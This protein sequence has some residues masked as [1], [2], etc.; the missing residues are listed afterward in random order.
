MP[1]HKILS[2]VVI[3][4]KYARYLP[5]K[6]RRETWEEIVDRMLLMHAK[7]LDLPLTITRSL[8][9]TLI[10]K[11]V[12]PSM[13]MLQFGGA[14]VEL[15]QS[16]GYNCASV[17]ADNPAIGWETMFLLLGGTGVGYSVQ[18]HHVAHLPVVQGPIARNRRHVIGDSIEGWAD[19]IK[20]LLRAYFEGRSSPVFEYNDIR[21]KGTLL[22]TSGGK[23]PGPA[24]LKRCIQAVR[25][26][27]DNAVGRQLKPIE[28]HSMLCHIADAVLAGGIRRAAMIALFSLNDLEMLYSKHGA[29]YEK[30]PH[31]GRANNSVMLDRNRITE[32][33][34]RRL[35]EII[36]QG[37]TGEPGIY[38]TNDIEQGTNPCVEIALR[39][40]Q[41]CNL[42][43]VNVSDVTTQEEL[44][45]RVR[46]ASILG[47]VQAS[48]TDFHYIREDWKQN[49]DEE[50]L[51]G[52]S[53]TG[54]ASGGVLH[55]D[56]E[57][58]AAV[59]V[60]VN[61]LW[62]DIL[63]INPAARVTCVKP[64]GTTSLVCGTSNG[65]HAWH[66]AYYLRRMRVGKEES[67]YKYLKD[68]LPQYVEDDVTDP[69]QAILTIPVKAPEG[70]TLRSESPLELLARVKKFSNEWI[71]P[72]HISGPNT[73][74][75]SATIP[76]KPE[77]WPEITDWMWENR[78]VY[79]GLSL[80]PFA[81]TAYKQT[82]F[83]EITRERYEELAKGLSSI[84]LTQ[85]IE[86]QDNTTLVG[87]AA[88]AGGACE[89]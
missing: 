13:R 1:A 82:P 17:A 75:V 50:S 43:E 64:A 37:G 33:R 81:P 14:S 25:A 2:D 15:N 61:R 36:E 48:Y 68:T 9:D 47:T 69:S 39:N 6:K 59:A 79:N 29:W 34:F 84:D 31:F 30:H 70:A 7:N 53:M 89:I 87:E 44:N 3:H 86:E 11:Q 41:F 10:A 62:A 8:R 83:E 45:R 5:E 23:A 51:L 18:L 42:T 71:K 4:M 19:A 77:E 32:S 76:V 72:G 21:E 85:V 28:V 20:V 26:V 35:M 40:M 67:I 65:I 88:C 38:F 12:L 74:N 27:F 66:A 80:L 24:P 57:E 58:A 49:C 73:H 55:L 22:V 60:A 54:I 63:G 52:V 56:L 46:I 78:E 16:R